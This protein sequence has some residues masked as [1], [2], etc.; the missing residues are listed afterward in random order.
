VT[1][2]KKVVL[3]EKKKKGSPREL[4]GGGGRRVM[5]FREEMDG[6]SEKGLKRGMAGLTGT[7]LVPVKDEARGDWEKR[8]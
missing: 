1:G 7:S 8:Q 2:Q 3:D 6:L 5:Q 4:T